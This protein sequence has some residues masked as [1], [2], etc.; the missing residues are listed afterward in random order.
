LLRHP[1]RIDHLRHVFEGAMSG[2]IL[3]AAA[4]AFG[5]WLFFEIARRM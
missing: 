5:A 2:A 1:R 3:D 4:L